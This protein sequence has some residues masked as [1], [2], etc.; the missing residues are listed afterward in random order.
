MH[1]TID[2][3]CSLLQNNNQITYCF[4]KVSLGVQSSKSN[5]LMSILLVEKR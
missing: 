5:T 1:P 2:A 4:T 3:S